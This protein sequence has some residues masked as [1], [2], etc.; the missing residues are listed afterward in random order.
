MGRVSTPHAASPELQD[1]ASLPRIRQTLTNGGL[2]HRDWSPAAC[3]PVGGPKFL[4]PSVQCGMRSAQVV[5][6][7]TAAIRDPVNCGVSCKDQDLWHELIALARTAPPALIQVIKL[8][9][10]SAES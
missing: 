10:P 1:G 7:L 3:R 2:W 6:T 9:Q 5:D 8:G 4:Q